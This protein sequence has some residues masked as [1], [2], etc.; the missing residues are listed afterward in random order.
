MGI[1]SQVDSFILTLIVHF[2]PMWWRLFCVMV[3]LS[4][5]GLNEK[6]YN[7]EVSTFRNYKNKQIST[8]PNSPLTNEQKES[9]QG[10]SYFGPDLDWRLEA[11]LQ[12]SNYTD[13][14]NLSPSS[15]QSMVYEK[16]GILQFEKKGKIFGLDAY[17]GK[18][19]NDGRLFVPFGDLTNGKSTYGGGRYVYATKIENGNYL[20]DFNYAHNPYCAYNHE[21]TCAL[22]PQQ[23][24]L[25][26]SVFVGEK[27]LFIDLGQQDQIN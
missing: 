6:A 9:F 3:F 24:I 11:E 12:K 1:L 7:E 20:L 15:D 14:I 13:Y 16:V 21:Y 5:C 17:I 23:N 25:D 4:S 18:G 22:P 2:C 27:K 8:D 19:E 26:I 10:L